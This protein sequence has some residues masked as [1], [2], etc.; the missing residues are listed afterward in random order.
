MQT[1]IVS[2][3]DI[4][5]HPTNRLDAAYWVGKKKGKKAYNKSEG[6]K[7]VESDNNGKIMLHEEDAANYNELKQQEAELQEKLKSFNL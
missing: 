1:A 6:G 7:L 5:S 2:L 3:R 4:T